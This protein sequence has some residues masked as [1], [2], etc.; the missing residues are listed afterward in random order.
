MDDFPIFSV[1]NLS[2]IRRK[3]SIFSQIQFNLSP[4]ELLIIEGENGSGKSSLLRLLSGIATPANGDINY[5]NESISKSSLYLA[6][7]HYID[8]TNGIKLGLTVHENLQMFAHLMEK[9][10][11]KACMLEELEALHLLT[12]LNTQT[13]YLSAGQKRRIALCKLFIFQKPVWILDE[14]LTALDAQTQKYF[15]T[16][17]TKH[18]Q[19]GGIAV[20]SSH[21]KVTLKH[22][23]IQTLRLS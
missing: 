21:H 22:D 10:L 17:L 6:D 18:L 23:A 1:T 5:R 19:Q 16:Q 2:C 7:M 15:Y 4:G 20:M 11:N 14:P 3:R 12:Y 9:D 8:H 13:L